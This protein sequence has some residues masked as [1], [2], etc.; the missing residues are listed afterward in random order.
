MTREDKQKFKAQLI[1]IGG[2][3]QS[4]KALMGAP[5]PPAPPSPP[6]APLMLQPALSPLLSALKM[7]SDAIDKLIKLVGDV[8]E[9]A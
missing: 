4:S 8:V 6:G 5:I 2:Q 3:L 9:S 7:Q 1:A